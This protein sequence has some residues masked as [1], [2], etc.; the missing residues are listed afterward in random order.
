MKI[1]PLQKAVVKRELLEEAAK[2]FAKFGFDKA[3]VNEIAIGAGYAKGTIYNYFNNKEE[4]FGEVIAE[5]AKFAVERYRSSSTGRTVKTALKELAKADVSLLREEESFI[6]VL[7]GEALNPRSDNFGLILTHLGEFIEM[8]SKI[9]EDGLEK[10]EIRDDVPIPQLALV[11][12]GMLTLLYIQ[13]WK[14]RGSWPSLDEIPDLVVTL[15][16]DGVGRTDPASVI[17]HKR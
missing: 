4:L 5:A 17:K 8:I 13:Y 11:F 2:H 6:K 3:N 14:S 10:R 15:F 7:V 9:L 12:L 16:I 1:T